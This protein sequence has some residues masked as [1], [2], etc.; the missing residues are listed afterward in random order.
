[1]LNAAEPHLEQRSSTGENEE[2]ESHTRQEHTNYLPNWGTSWNRFPDCTRQN[3]G[4]PPMRHHRQ[5]G[6]GGQQECEMQTGLRL[7]WES[8][9]NQVGVA[10]TCQ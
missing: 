3:R 5:H 6:K 1:M 7:H 2:R 4:R 8:C 9:G 10:V